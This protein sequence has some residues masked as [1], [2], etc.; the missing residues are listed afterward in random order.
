MIIIIGLCV[1]IIQFKHLLAKVD[2][3]C[4]VDHL[5]LNYIRKSKTEPAS[6]RIEKLI[7]VLSSYSFNLNYMKVKDMTLSNIVSRIEVDKFNTNEIIPI[8]PDLQ[9]VL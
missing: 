9:E 2:Y 3:D 1:N 8:S 5:A 7:K 6:S 4:T